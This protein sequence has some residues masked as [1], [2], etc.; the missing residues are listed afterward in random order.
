MSDIKQTDHGVRVGDVEFIWAQN[1][2]EFLFSNSILIHGRNPVIVDPSAN[3]TAIMRL[4]EQ[5]YVH[6]VL[7][8]HFHG[9]HRSLNHLFKDTYFAAHRLDAPYIANF[10]HYLNDAIDGSH[11]FYAEWTKKIFTR[12]KIIDCPISVLLSDGDH[13]NT[14]A[15]KIRAIHTPG[16]T[17]G[18]LALYFEEAEILFLSDIDLT[19]F[20]PWYASLL[21][22][23]NDF[24]ESIQKVKEIQA[25]Y[26]VPSHG[27]RL[28]DRETFLQKIERFEGHIQKREDRILKALEDGALSLAELS[29][30]PIVYKSLALNDPL[31]CY[32]QLQMVRKHIDDL[33]ERKII[34]QEGD[35]FILI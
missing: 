1:S 8:T 35:D 22:N 32:F 33:L 21:S 4:A 12:F 10:D 2:E 30:R 15:E 20:G 34:K 6:T 28:Y 7:N 17:P 3:F 27:E 9:D 25:R 18:H 11:S 26:Y 13:L 19:P 5:H 29:S 14:G 16:H 24:R 23:L 31:K